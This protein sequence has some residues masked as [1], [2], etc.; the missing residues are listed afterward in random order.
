MSVFFTVTYNMHSKL[1]LFSPHG[2]TLPV[3]IQAET[4]QQN[5]K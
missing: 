3:Q 5:N 4:F 1:L 2:I